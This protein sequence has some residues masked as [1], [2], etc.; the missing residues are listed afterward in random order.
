MQKVC[1][2]DFYS[3]S[4]HKSNYPDNCFQFKFTRSLFVVV[5]VYIA[6]YYI[7][8]LLFQQNIVSS[9]MV[10]RSMNEIE[11]KFEKFIH[12]IGFHPHLFSLTHAKIPWSYMCFLHSRC[13]LER[14]FSIILN[15]QRSNLTHGKFDYNVKYSMSWLAQL[16]VVQ[17]QL[18]R[19]DVNFR[20]S[21]VFVL[22]KIKK[23]KI[24]IE[25]KFVR[26]E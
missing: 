22:W 21:S 20:S 18:I 8:V 15:E 24:Q 19:Y 26:I 6:G 10:L 5:G 17:L 12:K 9:S 7:G 4:F 23:Y 16:F 14:I 1:S 3:E 13:I 2:R 11:V 25:Q